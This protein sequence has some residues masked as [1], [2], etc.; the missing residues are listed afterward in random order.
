M[1]TFLFYCIFYKHWLISIKF[2]T[3]YTEETC[4]TTIVDMST[5]PSHYCAVYIFP[6]VQWQQYAGEVD[7]WIIIMLQISSTYCVP[8]IAEIGH[9]LLKL[10]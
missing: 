4:N 10:Q 5:S 3:Q 1:S 2:G 6:K 7:K 9:R 8:N